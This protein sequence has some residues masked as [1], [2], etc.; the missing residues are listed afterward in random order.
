MT[1]TKS[2]PGT[3][4]LP[5]VRARVEHLFALTERAYDLAA[6][7]NEGLKHDLDAAGAAFKSALDYL[8]SLPAE[9][10]APRKPTTRSYESLMVG[11]TVRLREK[12]EKRYM[13]A[14]KGQP[15]TVQSV[16]DGWATVALAGRDTP[17]QVEAKHLFAVQS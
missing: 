2:K 15:L 17:C 13:G 11:D 16:E 4:R 6:H 8:D 9:F 5:L 12:A 7:W 10:V 3:A 14:L 1:E